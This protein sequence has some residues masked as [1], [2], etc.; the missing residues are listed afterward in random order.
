LPSADQGALGK[1]FFFKKIKNLCRVPTGLTLGKETVNRV[2]AVTVAF[3]Y[4]VR[5]RQRGLCRSIFYRV[6]FTEC[7]FTFAECMRT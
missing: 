4:R 2:G 1:E 5:S 3:L 6:F 7:N